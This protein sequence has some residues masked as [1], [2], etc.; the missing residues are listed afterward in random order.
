MK[1]ILKETDEFEEEKNEEDQNEERTR[2]CF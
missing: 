1:F 2:C